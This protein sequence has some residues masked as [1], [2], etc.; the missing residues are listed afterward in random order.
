MT[1]VH[2][3]VIKLP[4]ISVVTRLIYR[5]TSRTVLCI[6]DRTPE[7][8]PEEFL[9]NTVSIVTGLIAVALFA[10]LSVCNVIVKMY[11]ISETVLVLCDIP[12]IPFI[13]INYHN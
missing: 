13:V 9:L 1:S 2:L 3:T 8:L 4:I 7:N 11:Y 12:I 6:A 5:D 10:L